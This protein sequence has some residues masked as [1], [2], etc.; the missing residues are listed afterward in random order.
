MQQNERGRPREPIALQQVASDPHPR[1]PVFLA[2]MQRLAFILLVAAIGCG[3]FAWWGLFTIAGSRQF[4]E[5]DGF[6][7]FFVG[8]GGVIL[9]VAAAITWALTLRSRR[10]D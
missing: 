1:P 10:R 4:D 6:I 7:P 3:L 8:C 2:M 5:M 9:L